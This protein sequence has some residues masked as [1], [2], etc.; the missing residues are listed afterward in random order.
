[1][2]SLTIKQRNILKHT[3]SMA[4]MSTYPR[5]PFRPVPL[6]LTLRKPIQ[7]PPIPIVRSPQPFPFPS[8]SSFSSSNNK[9]SVSSLLSPLPVLTPLPN[10]PLSSSSTLPPTP[11]LSPCPPPRQFR[12]DGEHWQQGARET[13]RQRQHQR[14]RHGQRPYA[15]QMVQQKTV[16]MPFKERLQTSGGS[17]RK[18]RIKQSII[19]PFKPPISP[20]SSVSNKKP[21]AA[22]VTAAAAAATV[23]AATELPLEEHRIDLEALTYYPPVYASGKETETGGRGGGLDFEYRSKTERGRTKL[24]LHKKKRGPNHHEPRKQQ[25]Q[26][27]RALHSHPDERNKSQSALRHDNGHGPGKRNF[28]STSYEVNS[29]NNNKERGSLL[30]RPNSA[31]LPTGRPRSSNDGLP[32]PLK[33]RFMMKETLL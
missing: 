15:P 33:K 29:N 10:S 24:K 30:S 27:Q 12:D 16:S 22:V 19:T 31:V 7:P 5:L 14:Q 8:S 28:Y 17:L 25:Q 1:M 13:V 18:R 26:Q 9:M 4:A 11:S 6:I 20:R 3:L 32:M 2:C 23:A 21:S